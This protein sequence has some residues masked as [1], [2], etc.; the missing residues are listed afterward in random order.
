MENVVRCTPGPI[1]PPLHVVTPMLRDFSCFA[2]FLWY[3]LDSSIVGSLTSEQIT[4]LPGCRRSGVR[5]ARRPVS[6]MSNG[7]ARLRRALRAYRAE[8]NP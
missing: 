4:D 2:W 6:A 8:V 3:V 1:R 7:R 5:E